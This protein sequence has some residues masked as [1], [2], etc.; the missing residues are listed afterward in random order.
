MT[1]SKQAVQTVVASN[2]QTVVESNNVQAITESLNTVEA[3]TTTAIQTLL[4]RLTDA[5]SGLVQAQAQLAKDYSDYLVVHSE[6]E[7]EKRLHGRINSIESSMHLT[8]KREIAIKAG[9]RTSQSTQAVKTAKK[10]CDVLVSKLAVL[11]HIVELPEIVELNST[12]TAENSTDVSIEAE[13]TAYVA[14]Q[15][16]ALK[17]YLAAENAKMF[18]TGI[19]VAIIECKRF[20]TFNTSSYPVRLSNAAYTALESIRLA[21][22]TGIR[23]RTTRYIETLKTQ[24]KTIRDG[25]GNNTGSSNHYARLDKLNSLTAKINSARKQESD[26]LYNFLSKIGTN[27]ERMNKVIGIDFLSAKSRFES[28]NLRKAQS[29]SDKLKARVESERARYDRLKLITAEIQ[30]GTEKLLEHK[31]V[32]ESHN[33]AIKENGLAYFG[34]QTQI[35]LLFGD[36]YEL[37]SLYKAFHTQCTICKKTGQAFSLNSQTYKVAFKRG[38]HVKL[39]RNHYEAKLDDASPYGS[40]FEQDMLEYSVDYSECVY[41]D[42]PTQAEYDTAVLRLKE[43]E[44]SE[45]KKSVYANLE[46]E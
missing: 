45:T 27:E 18:D 20:T 11:G 7:A 8:N 3:T 31:E 12:I 24:E 26:S 5:K 21:V 43:L 32:L 28:A 6:F 30:T 25:L 34:T 10:H 41:R 17:G 44:T 29:A 19:E 16:N 36:N 14:T 33:V 22:I 37:K 40:Q 39:C 46:E 15:L 13:I 42:I 1:K 35:D 23:N 9:T 2:V 38:K 4:D